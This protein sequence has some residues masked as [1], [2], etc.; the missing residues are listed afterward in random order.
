MSHRRLYIPGPTEVDPETLARMSRPMIGHRSAECSALYAGLRARLRR[1]LG[2]ERVFQA[3]GSATM[4]MEAAVVNCVGRRCLNVTCGAFGERWH[5]VTRLR[6]IACDAQSVE[7]GRANDPAAID[8]ALAGGDYDAVTVTYSETSTGVL[9]P[10]AEIA[11]VVAGHDGVLLLVDAVSAMGAVP[12]P[13]D[14][15]GID[16]ALAGIQKAFGCPPGLVVFSVSD[17]AMERSRSIEGKGFYLDFETYARDD[18]KDQT[19]TT[20]AISQMYA[21]DHVLDLL[22]EEGF[23][24]V[25]ERHRAMS[26]TAC[27]WAS[28]RLALFPDPDHVSPTLTCVSA[29]DVD[30]P[31]LMSHMRDRGFVLGGGYGRLKQSTFRIA[32]MGRATP[33]IL[34][35]GLAAIDE[36]LGASR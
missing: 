25:Y 22:L 16:V 19:I 1:L 5:E 6:G 15:W 23:E 26:A 24:A 36:F 2:T 14:E 20:P 30:L 7:W 12:L 31:G 4:I 32:H 3:T 18:A 27:R 8:R 28:E 9:N 13:V 29:A 34:D 11:E 35:E 33:A 17:R 10:L 21:L